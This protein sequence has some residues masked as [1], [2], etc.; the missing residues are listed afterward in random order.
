MAFVEY[1]NNT[2]VF[3]WLGDLYMLLVLSNSKCGGFIASS[4][5]LSG[6]DS[7]KVA[8]MHEERI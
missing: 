8:I 5:A 2:Y 4:S 7:S 1:G 3:L 6:I